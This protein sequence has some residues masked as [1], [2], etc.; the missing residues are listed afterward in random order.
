M[1]QAASLSKRYGSLLALDDVSFSLRAGCVTGL[2]GPNGSGKTTTLRLALGLE[3]PT[4]G[5][6]TIDG[7]P[8]V[9]LE[10]PYQRVGALLDAAWIHP[11]RSA[12]AHLTWIC[13]ASRIPRANVAWALEEV[14]LT[15]V[16]DKP[17]GTF[18]LGMRQRLGLA[19]TILGKPE[20]LILDEPMN[21][22]D[23]DGIRW[24]RSF[25][26][27]RAEG[28]CAVLLASHLLQEMQATADRVLVL[29]RGRLLFDGTLGDLRAGIGTESFVEVEC[30]DPHAAERALNAASRGAGAAHVVDGDGGVTVVR[31]SDGDVATVGSTMQS[32]GIGVTRIESRSASLQEAYMDLTHDHD[33]EEAA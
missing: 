26:R 4:S 33:I 20:L 23:A 32:A 17:A 16:A 1:L 6:V 12:R 31:V 11:N 7:L 2:L 22:L 5:S 18:S 21:G 15:A 29:S 14:G 28:G 13:Q 27:G 19:S 24:I 10:Y 9:E 8:V 3:R 25:I 30:S